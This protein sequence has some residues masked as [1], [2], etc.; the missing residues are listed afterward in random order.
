M[1]K[2]ARV[3]LLA[4]CLF[5]FGIGA[6]QA[7]GTWTGSGT[8]PDGTVGTPYSEDL[9]TFISGLHGTAGSG[10]T[11][12]QWILN[13]GTLPPN[14]MLTTDPSTLDTLLAGTPTTASTYTFVLY[15]EGCDSFCGAYATLTEKVDPANG[16]PEPATW[17]LLL[18]GFVGLAIV[19]VRRTA[20]FSPRGEA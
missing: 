5:G 2:T 12:N 10:F 4:G 6:A 15:D 17:A 16:V 11:G 18:A 7:G 3:A 14:E 8:L 9:T 19:G 20:R 1:T 13:S